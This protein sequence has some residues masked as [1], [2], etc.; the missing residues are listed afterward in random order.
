LA[1][2]RTVDLLHRISGESVC[3]LIA[4]D[5]DVRLHVLNADRSTSVLGYDASPGRTELF[6]DGIVVAFLVAPYAER[7]VSRVE[8]VG[9]YDRDAF[10]F[11]PQEA[12]SEEDA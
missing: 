4:R 3:D 10:P 1:C 9:A 7:H 12:A 6:D 2:F 5:A 8:R 11:L